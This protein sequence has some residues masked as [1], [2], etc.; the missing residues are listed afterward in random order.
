M[1]PHY[2]PLGRESLVLELALMVELGMAPLAAIESCTRQAAR[3]LGVEDTLGTL[4]EGKLAD[5]LVV[6]GDPLED[7]TTLNRV[8]WVMKGGQ[9]IVDDSR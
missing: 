8:R 5:V 2:L 4:E 1:G 3:L 9:L 7:V 6:D